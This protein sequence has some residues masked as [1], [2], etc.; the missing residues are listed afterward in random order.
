MTPSE[1]AKV[2]ALAVAKGDNTAASRATGVPESTIRLWRSKPEF[3][4]LVERGREE[5]AADFWTIIQVA[6]GEVLAGMRSPDASLR[7]KTVA[8][9]I[10]FD[11]HALLTGAATAR[12]ETRDLSADLDDHERTALRDAIDAWLREGA[13]AAEESGA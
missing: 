2:V 8:L 7:D 9:G 1:K 5:V 13:G 11:K 6:L 4:Y 10:L 3:A 12:T